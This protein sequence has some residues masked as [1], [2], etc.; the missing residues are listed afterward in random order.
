MTEA[1]GWDVGSRE[2][3]GRKGQD[4]PGTGERGWVGGRLLGPRGGAGLIPPLSRSTPSG[5]EGEPGRSSA[6]LLPAQ[7]PTSTGISMEHGHVQVSGASM[8]LE[9]VVSMVSSRTMSSQDIVPRIQD[10]RSERG[11]QS[12]LV[13]ALG[14]D[15]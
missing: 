7:V 4:W 3:G 12:M 8:S 9:A 11:A 13:A 15:G 1:R 2:L 6:S 14:H 5:A 10:P